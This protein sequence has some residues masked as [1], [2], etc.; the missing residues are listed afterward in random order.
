MANL[1][2]P[3]STSLQAAY[4]ENCAKRKE[5]LACEKEQATKKFVEAHRWH[6][7]KIPHAETKLG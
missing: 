1:N 2:F 7:Y 5:R 3:P 6:K 4:T